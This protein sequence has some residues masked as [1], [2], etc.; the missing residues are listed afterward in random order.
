MKLEEFLVQ[1][2]K[3]AANKGPCKTMYERYL[4]LESNYLRYIH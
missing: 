1:E 4:R 2:A 3:I